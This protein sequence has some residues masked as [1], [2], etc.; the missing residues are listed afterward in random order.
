MSNEKLEVVTEI[1]VFGSLNIQDPTTV[2]VNE[3][4]KELTEEEKRKKKKL[5]EQQAMME[6][7]DGSIDLDK[8]A[9]KIING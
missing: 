3:A 5:M 6:N 4:A 9:N 8:L 2:E 7:A 1:G